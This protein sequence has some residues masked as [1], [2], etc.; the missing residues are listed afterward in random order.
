MK[1]MAMQPSA[2]ELCGEL[3][4]GPRLLSDVLGCFPA[5]VAIVTASGRNGA[6]Y[7]VT[8]SSFNSVSLDATLVLFSLS[9]RLLSLNGSILQ[10][11]AFAVNFLRDDQEHLSSRFGTALIDKWHRVEYRLGHTGSPIL[12][13]ALAILECWTYAQYDGGDH[14][15]VVGR[16][17]H[18][19]ADVG[20]PPLVLFRGRYH[21]V[22]RPEQTV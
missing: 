13:P 21:T 18:L 6:R 8:I 4:F 10:A 9:R 20:R 2:P 3:A 11:E 17:T 12:V 1:N 14:V 22:S 19:E 15:I 16:V 7:G 5:G